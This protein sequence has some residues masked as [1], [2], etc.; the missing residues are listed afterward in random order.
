[1]KLSI[2]IVSYNTAAL[3]DR[4]LASISQYTHDLD[5]EIIVVD[6]ASTDG[7]ADLVR[8]RYPAVRLILPGRNTFFSEG[9]NIAIRASIG[10]YVLLLNP[11]TEIHP[12]TLPTLLAHLEADPGCGLVTARQVWTD[13][14]TTLPI[15]SRFNTLAD[16]WLGATFAGTILPGWREQR[17]AQMWYAGWDRESDREVDVAPGS[18]MLI[19]PRVLDA[20]GLLDVD[21]PMYFSDDDLC[22]RI[23]QAGYT[24]RYLAGA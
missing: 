1:M 22:W 11:D 6:N 4:C 19:P 9:N 23:R 17:R 20:V 12:G 8:D 24:I 13:G 5:H 10:D 3:L 21:M 2:L 7:S 14:R 18:C 15:C 16:L